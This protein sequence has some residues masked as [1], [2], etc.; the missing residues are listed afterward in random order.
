L[1]L[2]FYGVILIYIRG[3][4]KKPPNFMSKETMM[5]DFFAM[6]ID[7]IIDRDSVLNTVYHCIMATVGIAIMAFL[8]VYPF[9]L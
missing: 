9:I 1:T 6:I 2:N 3:A 8:V 4:I 7:V 5:K